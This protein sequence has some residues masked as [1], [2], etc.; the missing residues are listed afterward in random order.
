MINIRGVRQSGSKGKLMTLNA[1]IEK[2]RET[3]EGKN[4]SLKQAK[5]VKLKDK[6]IK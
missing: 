1:L 2:R 4:L 6:S 3:R 5:V